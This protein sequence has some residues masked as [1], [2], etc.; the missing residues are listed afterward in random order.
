MGNH[1]SLEFWARE[2][3]K[4]KYEYLTDDEALT[5]WYALRDF[6]LRWQEEMETMVKGER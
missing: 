6:L 3:Y 1:S 4:K 5:V 2:L